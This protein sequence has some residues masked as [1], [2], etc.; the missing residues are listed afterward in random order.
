MG[1]WTGGTQQAALGNNSQPKTPKISNNKH[2]NFTNYQ[3]YTS[4]TPQLQLVASVRP[5]LMD[6]MSRKRNASDGDSGFDSAL[7]SRSSSISLDQESPE[8]GKQ[9]FAPTDFEGCDYAADLIT[10][11]L[12]NSLR[13]NYLDILNKDEEIS[14]DEDELLLITNKVTGFET[15]FKPPSRLTFCKSPPQVATTHSSDDYDRNNAIPRNKLFHARLEYELEKQ[16]EKMELVNVDLVMETGL[17]PPPSLGIRVIGVNMIHGVPDKLNIYVKRVVEDSVAGCDGRIRVNDHIVE[18]NGIS[19]VGVSQK[20]AAQTL[21]NCAICPETGTVHFV[22]ARPPPGNED[23]SEADDSKA[24]K[25]QDKA[26]TRSKDQD[27]ASKEEELQTKKERLKN[28]ATIN[29]VQ[30]NLEKDAAPIRSDVDLSEERPED[31]AAQRSSSC[32]TS[33]NSR[34]EFVQT[35]H[36]ILKTQT[37]PEFE[38]RDAVRLR[39]KAEE[40][41]CEDNSAIPDKVIWLKTMLRL[42]KVTVLAIT[43]LLANS[44]PGNHTT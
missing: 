38:G 8:F 6:P 41:R 44:M 11:K 23:S 15:L 43:I 4:Q 34:K 7:S 32:E 24:A 29:N 30:P 16:I 33:A 5:S 1:R 17:S 9:F 36:S 3:A 2:S 22:L 26:L 14:E 31:K 18:V 20:L 21:S 13:E 19:L 42:T 12:N 37:K 35:P 27:K 28:S 40:K 25:D 10:S 39:K